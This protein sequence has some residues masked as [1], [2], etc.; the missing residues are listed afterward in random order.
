MQFTIKVLRTA[1]WHILLPNCRMH[2]NLPFFANTCILF[3]HF[4]ISFSWWLGLGSLFGCQWNNA[5]PSDP[6]FLL[7]LPFSLSFSF[8]LF[9]HTYTLNH[10]SQHV[11][12]DHS[13]QCMCGHAP[14]NRAHHRGEPSRPLR[15]AESRRPHPGCERM[16]HH[17]QVPLWHCQ[18][19]QGGREHRHTTHHSWRWWVEKGSKRLSN[20]VRNCFLS[21][22]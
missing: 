19:H 21:L 11:N 22:K 6:L 9:T 20:C 16:L 17:Q 7:L 2:L 4:L 15:E 1:V 13:W 12:G 3:C 8:A 10:T 18:P 5:S 14:Q